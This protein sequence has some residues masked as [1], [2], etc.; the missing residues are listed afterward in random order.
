MLNVTAAN[1]QTANKATLRAMC[2]EAGIVASTLSVEAMRTALASSVAS[3]E[4]APLYSPMVAQE[5]VFVP[6]LPPSPLAEVATLPSPSFT[7]EYFANLRVARNP[8]VPPLAPLMG[9]PSQGKAPKAPKA[10]KVPQP[11][12]NGVKRPKEGTICA[13]IW[14]YCEEQMA[15]G[16][17]PEAKAVRAALCTLDATTCTVQY[18]RWRTFSGIRGR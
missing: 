14:A 8:F 7:A 11:E 18:Y 6:V 4:V 3:P 9:N 13:R 15:L 2:K 10:A 12:Q 5:P 16:V 17:R 1:L